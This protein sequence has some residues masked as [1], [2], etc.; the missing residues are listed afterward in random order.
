MAIEL[1]E[2][3]LLL[4][5]VVLMLAIDERRL[6]LDCWRSGKDMTDCA[7][8]PPELCHVPEDAEDMISNASS[9]R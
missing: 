7:E 2:F 9:V 5:L 8:T 1:R 4:L 6:E 3:L